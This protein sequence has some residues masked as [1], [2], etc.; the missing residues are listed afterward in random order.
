MLTPCLIKKSSSG[1]RIAEVN[2]RRE[3][4]ALERDFELPTSAQG[5]RQTA[6]N[7]GIPGPQ[8]ADR[9]AERAS[10]KGVLADGEDSNSRYL[11]G[12]KLEGLWGCR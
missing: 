4:P 8:R 12:P 11:I 3:S 5:E 1:Y 2:S 10:P 9:R 6:K 7:G